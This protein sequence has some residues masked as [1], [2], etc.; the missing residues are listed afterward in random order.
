M[1]T[2]DFTAV[3]G[4]NTVSALLSSLL[5]P[6]CALIRVI[7][8]ETLFW[9]RHLDSCPEQLKAQQFVNRCFPARWFESVSG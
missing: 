7:G 1:V 6:V 5:R 3:S 9:P 8:K 4:Q 2:A